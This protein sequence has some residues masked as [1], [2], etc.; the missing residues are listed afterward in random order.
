MEGKPVIVI[1]GSAGGIDA[2]THILPVLPSNFALPVVV[3]LHIPPDRPSG[4]PELFAHRCLLSVREAEDKDILEPSRIYFAPPNYHLLIESG[5]SLALSID[6][7]VNFSRPS[8]DV[9]FESA[10]DAL[11]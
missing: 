8:I 11:G 3:T 7:P 4:I 1:G 2:L 10:S 5:D 9:L 6:P